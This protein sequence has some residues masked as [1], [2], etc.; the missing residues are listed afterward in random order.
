MG[1]IESLVQEYRNIDSVRFWS[2]REKAS[3]RS[4]I[5]AVAVRAGLYPEFM[6]AID[7]P[8]QSNVVR[9]T[10]RAN[11]QDAADQASKKSAAE[12]P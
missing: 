6:M 3:A 1:F 8:N 11:A 7:F 9:L 10:D 4:A 5:R 2:A 12:A